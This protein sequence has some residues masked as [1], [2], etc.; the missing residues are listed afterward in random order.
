MSLP[1]A[2]QMLTSEQTFRPLMF[3][4]C[5][6]PPMNIVL[7]PTSYLPVLQVPPGQIMVPQPVRPSP[8]GLSI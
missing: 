4:P 2:S 6:L 1:P 7:R 3:P 8:F 5:H